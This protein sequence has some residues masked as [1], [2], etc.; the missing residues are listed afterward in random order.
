MKLALL[1]IYL[2]WGLNWVVMKEANNYF[3]P[4]N[5]VAWRYGVGALLLALI[6]FKKFGFK[7]P[8]KKLWLPIFFVGLFLYA[9]SN[10]LIQISMLKISAGMA[11]VIN[12]TMPLWISIIAHFY[13][14]ETLTLRKISGIIISLMGLAILMG[15]DF[16]VP[17]TSLILSLCSAI[18]AA[19]GNAIIK[20]KI[21]SANNLELTTWSM[22]IGAVILIVLNIITN[23]PPA[24][25][26]LNSVL[27]IIYNGVLA[28]ALAFLLWNFVLSKMEAANAASSI[29][30]VPVVGVIGGFIFLGESINLKML[31]GMALILGGVLIVVKKSIKKS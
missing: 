12:Y 31:L 19:V 21:K 29:L 11:A 18:A 30:L 15:I 20:V 13:L 16:D 2:I 14:D 28:S 25:W 5:F 4:L 9:L 10:L 1:G 6:Y 3:S 8:D 22:I 26:N 7:L 27:I 17:L 23:Q 24:L